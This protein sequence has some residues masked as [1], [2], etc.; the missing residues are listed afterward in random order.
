MRV[1]LE[2]SVR[3][4]ARAGGTA[5][6]RLCAWSSHFWSRLRHTPWARASESP[7]WLGERWPTPQ[8]PDGVKG[9]TEAC[10][11]AGSTAWNSFQRFS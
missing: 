2:S 9:S 3:T 11:T 6:A 7:L 4:P 5:E 8:T 1:R 10:N